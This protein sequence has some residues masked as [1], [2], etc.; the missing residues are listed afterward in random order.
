MKLTHRE[1]NW[2]LSWAKRLAAIEYKGGVCQRCGLNNIFCMEFHHIDPKNKRFDIRSA[3]NRFSWS[4]VKEELDKCVMYCANCHSEVEEEI[5]LTLEYNCAGQPGKQRT[6]KVYYLQYKFNYYEVL[7]DPKCMWCGYIGTNNRSLEFHHRPGEIKLFNISD[8]SRRFHSVFDLGDTIKEELD[9]CD[10]T[11][12]NCH[13]IDRTNT[14]R[15]DRLRDVIYN[16]KDNLPKKK[17]LTKVN[18]PLIYK[19]KD[20]GWTNTA[21]AKEVGC[22][23]SSVTYALQVRA[24]KESVQLSLFDEWGLTN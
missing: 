22:V 18:R 14:K 15:F 4:V 9:K 10:V 8:I 2:T 17:E 21:I 3:C 24:K 1:Y 23:R 11:C 16:K 6:N 20:I 13:V 5:A 19:L 7:G 12:K